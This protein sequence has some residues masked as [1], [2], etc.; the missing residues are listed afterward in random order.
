MADSGAVEPTVHEEE[1]MEDNGAEEHIALE[2]AEAGTSRE[3]SS[4][5]QSAASTISDALLADDRSVVSQKSL[6]DPGLLEKVKTLKFHKTEGYIPMSTAMKKRYNRAIQKGLTREEALKE[7]MPGAKSAPAVARNPFAIKATYSQVLAGV[8]LGIVSDDNKKGQLTSADLNIIKSAILEELKENEGVERQPEFES[9]AFK[10][11]W[12]TVYCSNE[13]TAE[14]VRLKFGGIKDKSGLKIALVEQSEFP[15]TYVV[16]GYFGDSAGDKSED[17]LAFIQSQNNLPAK[18]WTVIQRESEGRV[19]HLV[20]GL[21]EPSYKALE[22]KGGRIA[23]KFGHVRMMLGKK[24]NAEALQD[25]AGEPKETNPKAASQSI[26][27]AA[28]K[29][30][31]GPPGDKPGSAKVVIRPAKLKSVPKGPSKAKQAKKTNKKTVITAEAEAEESGVKEPKKVA[32]TKKA[33][34]QLELSPRQLR[35]GPRSNM[36]Q[37]SIQNAFAKGDGK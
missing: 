1:V 18:Q 13:S 35:K 22:E 32:Q 11:G 26:Q 12:M 28:K 7:A 31:E 2:Q 5:Q 10:A 25:G 17:I 19:E 23:Y 27:G 29:P 21:D 37:G 16:N 33:P 14:W 15:K 36:R 4:S 24:R 34:V 3:P 9:I 30:K 20:L 8:K 6:G